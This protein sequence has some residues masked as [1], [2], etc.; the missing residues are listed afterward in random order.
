[1]QLVETVSL[2]NKQLRYLVPVF[3][4]MLK[5]QFPTYN[6]PYSEVWSAEAVS[7]DEMKI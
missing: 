5:S 4:E 6:H 7:L 1:M 3:Q 2:R